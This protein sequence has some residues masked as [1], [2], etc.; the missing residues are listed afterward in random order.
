MTEENR[1]FNLRN[2]WAISQ[3]EWEAGQQLE[4]LGFFRQAV[5]RYYYSLYHAVKAALLSRGLEPATHSGLVSEFHRLFV[6]SGHL[7]PARARALGRLQ[8]EREE[9]DYAP[10]IQFSPS[11]AEQARQSASDLRGFIEQLLV[12]EDWL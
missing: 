8:R 10:A 7:S 9:A 1:R 2:E 6:H 3:Q 11:D 5:G 12:A 4:Q